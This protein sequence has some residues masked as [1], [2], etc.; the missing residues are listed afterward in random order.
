MKKHRL[1]FL[2]AFIIFLP[3]NVFAAPDLNETLDAV[4]NIYTFEGTIYSAV[5]DG[6]TLY[7]G[8]GFSTVTR[9]NGE[10]MLFDEATEEAQTFPKITTEENP[11]DTVYSTISD[12][13]GGWYVGGSFTHV[14]GEERPALI[15]VLADGSVDENFD[16]SLVIYDT[17]IYALSLS[18]DG[19]T[20]Y[21]GGSFTQVDGEPRTDIAALDA[22][23]GALL[24]I[25]FNLTFFCPDTIYALDISS[26]GDTLYAAG[27][28][29]NVEG[30]YS[31]I[32]A[33]DTET[34]A[35]TSMGMYTGGSEVYA[36]QLSSD[37]STLYFGG[38]FPSFF[39][40]IPGPAEI[41]DQG[42]IG[43]INTETIELTDFDPELDGTVRALLLSDDDQ[44]LYV[45]G[46][47]ANVGIL[48]RNE[49]AAID[50]ETGLATALD[51]GVSGGNNTVLAIGL[52][53]DGQ[54]LYLGGRDF[55]EVGGQVRSYF[56]EI[57]ATT[58][59]ATS[60]YPTLS[61][62]VYAIGVADG[63]VLIGGS[64]GT[65][66]TARHEVAAID[67]TTYELTDFD[68]DITGVVDGTVYALALS[69]EGDVLY[70]GGNISA[71]NND[72][73]PR[74]NLLS[75]H[76]SNG[77]ATAFDPDLDYTVNAL[78]VSSDG[79]TVYAGGG[80]SS[81]NDGGVNQ[82]YLAAFN[83]TTGVADEAFIPVVDGEVYS[84]VLSS[85][86]QTLY[87]A[88]GFTGGILALD[89]TTGDVLITPNASPNSSVYAL[90]LSSDETT[91][92][93]GGE[94]SSF[95]PDPI[96][97]GEGFIADAGTGAVVGSP[98]ILSTNAQT[99]HVSIPDGNGGWYVGGSFN[100]VNGEVWGSRII[101]ILSDNTIDTNFEPDFG[102]DSGEV[103]ALALAD[104]GTLYAGGQ[105]FNLGV[106]D[107]RV[108]LAAFDTSDGSLLPFDP[109]LGVY[110]NGALV[111]TL[112]LDGT[113]LYVGGKFTCVGYDYDLAECPEGSTRNNL[114]AIDTETGLATA[115]DPN[116]SGISG[117]YDID[118]STDGSVLYAGGGFTTVNG[119]QQRTDF[120]AFSLAPETLGDVTALDP[121][122]NGAP[123]TV[124]AI[125]ESSD[126]STVY[127]GGSFYTTVDSFQTYTILVAVDVEANGGVGAFSETFPSVLGDG[128]E[129][130]HTLALSADDGTLYVGGEVWDLG[131]SAYALSTQ[132]GSVVSGFDVQLDDYYT[133]YTIGTPQNGEIFIGGESMYLLGEG[134]GARQGLAALDTTDLS[135]TDFNPNVE[136][137]G[138]Y[139]LT[140][141]SDDELLYVG[142]SQDGATYLASFNTD[143]TEA[144]F[145]PS[146]LTSG[147]VYALALSP[148]D[149]ELYVA[150]TAGLPG[151][152]AIFSSDEVAPPVEEEEDSGGSSGSRIR[153]RVLTTSGLLE[154]LQLKLIELLKQYLQLL[155]DG[156]R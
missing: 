110:G 68:P 95:N 76:T 42:Y 154:Q 61:S 124:H 105:F 137:L 15:H 145:S 123:E 116:I 72:T 10:A 41:V 89:A 44:T 119:D 39:D 131:T 54:T 56:A 9:E 120:A 62:H 130:V 86:G 92:Y 23:T 150:G 5:T 100:R 4:K 59:L 152:Y 22:T 111:R 139:S 141:S 112:E 1:F 134:G 29:M 138:V 81:V 66:T 48:A 146:F 87:G 115:F 2:I 104:D 8:G 94:F 153:D 18:P 107:E 83:A 7:L 114:A 31:D 21:I 121:D 93:V 53:T 77:N 142:G 26:T 71:V 80:F 6:E 14:D 63:Q 25:D 67:L 129:V 128:G 144:A 74:N 156:Q 113:T 32:V 147:Y 151:N 155:L 45:G 55:T 43:A 51:A 117:V 133:V 126:G 70:V 34:G 50:T 20:L 35:A 46:S 99:V 102:G 125:A 37:D 28:C 19:G 122:I 148:D 24:P 143:G 11:N 79:T 16:A 109:S 30:V 75:V 38:S 149:D 12:G 97:V 88:G 140:L 69:P 60:F 3:F 64:F 27:D 47:F 65:E 57:D 49:F 33:L 96:A 132:D 73:I 103:Y 91:L 106:D 136:V 13:N 52:S 85:D 127:V 36:L 135:L 82:P 84:L 40:T 58:G 17:T 101:H 78:T 98:N 108:G 118:I 90:D